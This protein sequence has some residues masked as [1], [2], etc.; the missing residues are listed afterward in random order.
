MKHRRNNEAFTL[1]EIVVSI[2]LLALIALLLSRVFMESSR[3]V[4]QGIDTASMDETARLLMDIVENDIGQALVR[5]DTPFRSES[6]STPNDTLY[7]ISTAIR[8]QL[9]TIPRDTA[10]MRIQ[11]LETSSS[12]WTL[13]A[14]EIES[15]ENAAGNSAS[16][17]GNLILFSDYYG[18]NAANALS[19]FGDSQNTFIAT[20]TSLL[21]N[22]LEDHP[23]LTFLHFS[24]NADPAWTTSGTV[25]ARFVD[26]SFGLIP[27]SD[28]MTAI[29]RNDPSF[30]TAR[31]QVYARRILIRNSLRPNTLMEAAP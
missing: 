21:E 12:E 25:L 27:S 2:T 11:T 15:P 31:E 13:L 6:G 9:E 8:R 19:D 10:P 5:P 3:V 4:G 22:N 1:L 28:L 17:R 16:T 18:L 26:V 7:F 30:K 29:R 24:V 14:F 23:V 20:Y